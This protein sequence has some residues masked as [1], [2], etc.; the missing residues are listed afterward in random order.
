M[1]AV[2]V[3]YGQAREHSRGVLV[4]SFI[5]RA[6]P[7]P[8]GGRRRADRGVQAGARTRRWRRRARPSNSLVEE[9]NS[10]PRRG[11]GHEKVLTRLKFDHQAMRLLEAKGLRPRQRAARAGEAVYLRSTA[12]LS[13]GGTAVDVTDLVH[14]DNR[15]MAQR[16]ALAIGLDVAGVDFLTTDITEVLPRDRR[17]H[18]RSQRGARVSACTSHRPRASR[19]TQPGR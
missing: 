13:T 17:R 15:E 4:E 9:V 1:E 5:R 2:K 6:R 11:I 18:L 3:A 10:D 8:A 16:A 12:N 7:P 14:P 19:V